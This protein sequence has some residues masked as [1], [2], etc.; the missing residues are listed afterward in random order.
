MANLRSVVIS[1]I[2]L[3]ATSVPALGV[4]GG[5]GRTL[6]GVWIQPQ[7]VPW[8]GQSQGLA[9]LRCLCDKLLLRG[10]KSNQATNQRGEPYED[11]AYLFPGARLRESAIGIGA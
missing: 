9:S 11:D 6:P 2:A 10:A 7:G 8:S 4:E 5:L 1:G 3:A